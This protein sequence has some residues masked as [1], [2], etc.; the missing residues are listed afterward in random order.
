[1]TANEEARDKGEARGERSRSASEGSGDRED[2]GG[3]R[4]GATSRDLE[5]GLCLMAELESARDRARE[6]EAAL[7]RVRESCE[8]SVEEVSQ[9]KSKNERG[10]RQVLYVMAPELLTTCGV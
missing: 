8:R 6:L 3:A 4:S 1:M 10:K 9:L 5:E 7:E 2:G